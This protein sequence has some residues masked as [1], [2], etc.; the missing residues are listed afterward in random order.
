[1]SRENE[2][3]TAV[4]IHLIDWRTKEGHTQRDAA[5]IFDMKPK[6]YAKYEERKVTGSYS[7][8]KVFADELKI[9]VEELTSVCESC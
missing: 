6:A 1:M 7:R 2:T 8:L 5:A 4:A 9:T 3:R